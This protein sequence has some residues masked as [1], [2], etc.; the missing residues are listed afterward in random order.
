[1][2]GKKADGR[3]QQ[4]GAKS[5]PAYFLTGKSVFSYIAAL[6]DQSTVDT[7]K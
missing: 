2:D 7:N 6:I 5:Y 1:M 3:D 4:H